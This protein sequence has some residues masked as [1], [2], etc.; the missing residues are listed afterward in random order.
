LFEFA[1]LS[2]DCETGIS[3]FRLVPFNLRVSNPYFFLFLLLVFSDCLC[4]VLNL[5]GALMVD[6][7]CLVLTAIA[8]S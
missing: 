7:L 4:L 6:C 2:W 8:R 5:I 3:S 1:L